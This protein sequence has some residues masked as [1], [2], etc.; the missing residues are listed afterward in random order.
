MTATMSPG[1]LGRDRTG[2]RPSVMADHP[3]WRL[4]GEGR[5]RR[6]LRGGSGAVWLAVATPRPDGG[7]DIGLHLVDGQPDSEPEVE[8]DVIDPA[9]LANQES[10]LS[11]ELLAAGPV[12]RIRAGDLWE[13][14]LGALFRCTM[15]LEH[16][17]TVYRDAS[18]ALGQGHDSP[19]GREWLFP[20]P[21]TVLELSADVFDVHGLGA[22]RDRLRTAAWITRALEPEWRTAPWDGL[23]TVLAP[24][25]RIGSLIA[26]AA[27]ADLS[28]DFRFLA[29]SDF[30]VRRCVHALDPA[31]SWPDDAADF[32]VRWQE[33]TGVQRS[34]W[35]VLVLA[36]ETATVISCPDTCP[37]GRTGGWTAP[38]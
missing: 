34:A 27:V 14:L 20:G 25:P 23:R 13:A 8:V 10:A 33:M 37:C 17:R 29:P 6:L 38:C 31:T 5:W 11:Q 1:S 32:G 21:T 22:V 19:M 12:A 4:D 2:R 28:G 9:T 7:H 16:A 35:N 24:V 3:G 36:K 18:T 30:L 15:P 26:D